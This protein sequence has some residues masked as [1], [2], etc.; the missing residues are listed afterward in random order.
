MN[1]FPR[2]RLILVLRGQPLG[3]DFR[4]HIP[5]INEFIEHGETWYVVT[6]VCHPIQTVEQLADDDLP[7][8]RLVVLPVQ[9]CQEQM[10]KFFEV[11]EEQPEKPKRRKRA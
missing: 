5:Q 11:L 8:V 4:H 6:Q 10:P 9:F 7:T 3:M 1:R 2:V